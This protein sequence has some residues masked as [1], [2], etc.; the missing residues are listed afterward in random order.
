MEWLD[1]KAAAGRAVLYVALGALAAIP[2]E[3]A[4]LEEVADGLELA[5][6][7]FIWT[8]RPEIDLGEGFEDRTKDRGLV[9]REWVDQP[10]ILRHDS[11]RGFLSHCRWS[12]VLESVAAGVPLAVWPT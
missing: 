5:E 6:V 7:D 3:E 1:E 9:V 8:V 10:A 11:V 4:P 12:S 2:E